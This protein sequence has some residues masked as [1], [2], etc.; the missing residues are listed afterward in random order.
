MNKNDNY[1]VLNDFSGSRLDRWIKKHY[2][3]ISHGDLEVALRKGYIKV[4][5]SKTKSN[6]RINLFDKISVNSFLRNKKTQT[7][8][9][10]KRSSKKEIESMLI[11]ED[12]EILVINKP[13]GIAVQGGSKINKHIDGLL[14]SSYKSLQPRLV[15]RIDKETSGILLVALNRKIADFL[16]YSFREKK[17]TKYYWAI[18]YGNLSE[19]SGVIDK[20]I[21]R[22]NSNTYTDAL[23]KYTKYMNFNDKLN[24]MIYKPITG[25]N[26]QIRIHSYDL[27][28]PILGDKK[29]GYNLDD[30][31]KLHLHSKS[32]EFFHP[33]GKKMYFE[34][35]LPPHMQETWNLYN[36]P[37]EVKL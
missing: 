27:G 24:F 18:T 37:Y 29:Y 1:K 30:N 2:P 21:K 22:K 11:Y 10:Y 16:S 17:I 14:Q 3:E 4:N 31:K 33:N 9:N 35:D 19:K 36:L 25:R 32:I 15:H 7:K 5:D 6:Y 12:D 34:A 28:V 23:T 13:H 20:R 26:H 8:D